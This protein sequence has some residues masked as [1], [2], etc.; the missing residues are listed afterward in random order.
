MG[1]VPYST[2]N[3]VA[4]ETALILNVTATFVVGPNYEPIAAMTATLR[5]TAEAECCCKGVWFW[6]LIVIA[7]VETI[8]FILFFLRGNKYKKEYDALKDEEPMALALFGL[9]ST[10]C[11]AICIALAV[12]DAILL[13]LWI[14]ALVRLRSYK[15]KCGELQKAP[16]EEA[17][18]TPES[19]EESSA[20]EEPAG[21]E[22]TKATD[23]E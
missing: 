8:L 23:D 15:K 2:K 13:G 7:I 10:A 21:A 4:S 9:S 22:E 16:K 1:S 14:W 11:L 18:E 3:P 6:I 19:S 17:P 20:S 12:L 5:I